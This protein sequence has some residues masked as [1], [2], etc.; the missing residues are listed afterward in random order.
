MRKQDWNIVAH[1]LS[2]IIF[3][4]SDFCL[5]VFLDIHSCNYHWPLLNHYRCVFKRKMV[6][7]ENFILLGDLFECS[8][9]LLKTQ[10]LKETRLKL[11]HSRHWACRLGSWRSVCPRWKPHRWVS[12]HPPRGRPCGSCWT[13]LS[14]HHCLP[15][16]GKHTW[17]F[18]RGTGSLGLWQC[19]S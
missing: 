10:Q 12:A 16:D 14:S 17:Q 3:V 13:W 7:N 1:S 19:L 5:F 4:K 18:S 9:C 8:F 11:A 2:R 6:R 15:A